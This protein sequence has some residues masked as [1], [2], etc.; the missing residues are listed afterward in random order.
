MSASL[1]SNST[2]IA[3]NTFFLYLRSFFTLCISLYTSRVVL[4]V[5]GVVDYGIFSV[6][7]TTIGMVTFINNSMAATYQRYFNYEMG[8][9]NLINLKNIF[10]SSITVQIIY[11][12]IIIVIAETAGLWFLENKMIIPAD[13]TYAAHFIYHL[14]IVSFAF[15]VLSAPFNALIIAYE[16]MN[17]FAYVSIFD[18]LLKLT[19]VLCL[20]YI[21][22]DN[23]IVY[24]FFSLF[25]VFTSLITYIIVCKLKFSTCELSLNFNGKYIN[26]LLNFGTWGMIDSLSYSLKSQGLNILLNIFFGPVVNTARGIAYQILSAVDQFVQSFQ[27]S[28]RPQI[29]KS[30][31]ECNYE[32]MY[33]LY[34]HLFQ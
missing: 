32:Y 30:Y 2:R 11:A 20:R 19:F 17:I 8:Q 9:K 14:S 34:Y 12:V 23:L 5:L 16:K 31:S 13:R 25:Q 6:V 18:S 4:D 24:G 15:S 3:K 28:F 7:A 27:T 10:R 33:K 29:V 1:S 22:G 26:K 21:P